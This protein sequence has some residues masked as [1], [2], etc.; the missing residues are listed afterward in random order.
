MVEEQRLNEGT[1]HQAIQHERALVAAARQAHRRKE[2]AAPMVS[3]EKRSGK[4][5]IREKAPLAQRGRSR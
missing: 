4:S 2:R 3:P 5:C 1:V